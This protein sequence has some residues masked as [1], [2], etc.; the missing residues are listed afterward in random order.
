[1]TA[2][3]WQNH[4]RQ[5]G[6]SLPEVRAVISG[7]LTQLGFTNVHSDD[8]K[9]A[10]S[11]NGCIVDVVHMAAAPGGF[12]EITM[13]AGGDPAVAEQTRDEVVG[14]LGNLGFID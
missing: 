8:M 13:C 9:V 6:H 4:Q 11:K 3:S 2:L 1:M 7:R 10:G 5:D 14:A 12:W